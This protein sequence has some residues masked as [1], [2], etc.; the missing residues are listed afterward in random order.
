MGISIRTHK[1]LWGASGNTCAKCKAVVVQ[2]ATSV[3]GPSIVGEEAHIVSKEALGPRYDD[4][5]AMDER[6]EVENLLILCNRCH[7]IVDDQVNTYTVD[8]LRRI[9]ADHEGWVRN[10]LNSGGSVS[11]EHDW[12]AYQA[13]GISS[14]CFLIP[15]RLL[16]ESD[17]VDP[18]F[19]E[20]LKAQLCQWIVLAFGHTCIKTPFD[21]FVYLMSLERVDEEC[22]QGFAPFEFS[23]LCHISDFIWAFQEWAQF[24]LGGETEWKKTSRMK[25]FT[26]D[27][28]FRGDS[29]LGE[30]VPHRIRRL[31]PA[32]ITVEPLV[33]HPKPFD[34]RVTTSILLHLMAHALTTRLILWDDA[35]NCPDLM[36]VLSM[37]AKINDRKR[38][39]WGDIKL[40]RRNPE[41]WVYAPN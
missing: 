21:D 3:D 20:A 27:Q 39:S 2:K 29:F 22:K 11:V 4:P 14:C 41:S 7:K 23:L 16:P 36:K 31:P 24:F 18:E 25:G 35:D 17:E 40:D 9:K 26:G 30:L 6:D 1:L 12:M 33:Q 5:L 38:L 8:A 13:S 28:V 32:E 19:V 37:T 34:Q 15:L 10:L